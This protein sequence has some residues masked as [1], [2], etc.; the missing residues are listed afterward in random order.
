MSDLSNLYISA[1]YYGVV[2][3]TD[4]T[5]PFASQSEGR[6]YLHDGVGENLGISL[7]YTKRVSIDNG[8]TV[9]GSTLLSG[10]VQILGDKEITGSL[11]V[12]GNITSGDTISSPTGSFDTI[13]A[14][15]I[16]TTIESSSIIYST[17]SNTLGDEPSDVQIF[18]G[19]VYVPNLHYLAGNPKDTNLRIDEK[20]STSSFDSFSSSLHTEQEVQ[21]GRITSLESFSSSLEA[22]FVSDIEYSSSIEI[23]TSSL[24]TYIDNQDA[25][26]LNTGSFNTYSSSIQGELDLKSDLTGN[27]TFDGNNTFSGSVNGEVVSLSVLSQTASMDC[28]QGNF[29]TLQLIS[30]SSSHLEPLNIQPGQTITLKVTQPS[31]GVGGLSF[32][33]NVK[34]PNLFDYTPTQISDSIDIVTFVTFDSNEILAVASNNLL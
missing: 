8:L 12:S 30:G 26:K 17:G 18:S 20:L 22:D 28:S 23:V 19:S 32:K 6:I 10:S 16:H 5:E 1:S 11:S 2:N 3:L 7:D 27:N 33:S 13:N 9:S 14:R 21:D 34:F 31:V 4:S 25:K 24:Y 29:F 15:L